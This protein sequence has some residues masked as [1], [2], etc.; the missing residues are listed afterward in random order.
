M[1]GHLN[2]MSLQNKDTPINILVVG[3][4][5]KPNLLFFACLSQVS[6]AKLCRVIIN[7]LKSTLLGPNQHLELR[8]IST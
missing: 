5:S 7:N 6:D 4:T 1:A 8:V 2:V 3:S